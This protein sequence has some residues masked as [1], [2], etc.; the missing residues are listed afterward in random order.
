MPLAHIISLVDDK[1][2]TASLGDAADQAA[3]DRA[4]KQAA[5][6]YGVDSPRALVED[7]GPVSG[8]TVPLPSA[9]VVDRSQL[10]AVEHPIGSVPMVGVEAAMSFDGSSWSILLAEPLAAP[11]VRVHFT[12]PHVLTDTQCTIP[13][14]HENAVASWAAAELCRQ[15][16]TQKGH[17]REATI[18][19]AA[20]NGQSA[21]GDLA[22]RAKDWLTVYRVAL[23][24][25][26]PD[27]V[28]G[29][30]PTGTTVS[31]ESDRRRGR[32]N[33]LGV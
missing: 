10:E 19:A 29:P 7:V 14:E 4:I 21:S 6:Q 18:G 25:S 32:F 17:D 31:F 16:A 30:R 12:A 22:R 23:G 1:L 27:K 2:R 15:M 5:L 9:W 28:S 11:L 3:R 20:V 13:A 24:L 26:D 33:S 8:G